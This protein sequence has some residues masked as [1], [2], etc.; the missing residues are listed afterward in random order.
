MGAAFVVVWAGVERA[1]RPHFY[2]FRQS[3]FIGVPRAIAFHNYSA[4]YFKS[5]FQ[6]GLHAARIPTKK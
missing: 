2:F 5:H 4:I 6:P 3:F 1:V